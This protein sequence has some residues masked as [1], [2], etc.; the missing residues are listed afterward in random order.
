MI[1]YDRGQKFIYTSVDVDEDGV[2]YF[3]DLTI[4]LTVTVIDN[5]EYI[6]KDNAPSPF[7]YGVKN[8]CTLISGDNTCTLYDVVTG[9]HK[10][11]QTFKGMDWLY[12]IPQFPSTRPTLP[13]R[14]RK[15][16]PDGVILEKEEV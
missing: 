11:G 5:I 14:V 3:V 9:E 2:S 10:E 12:E 15:E 13:A 6:I 8:I 7:I 1:Y 4:D 16:F